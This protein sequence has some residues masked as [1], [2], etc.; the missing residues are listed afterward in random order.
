MKTGGY[1]AIIAVIFIAILVAPQF[2]NWFVEIVDKLTGEL[3]ANKGFMSIGLTIHYEDGTTEQIETEKFTLVPLTIKT[4]L[5]LPVDRLYV[6]IAVSPE[7]TIQGEK[8]PIVSYH[9]AGTF[10][11]VVWDQAETTEIADW[12]YE[13]FDRTETLPDGWESGEQKGVEAF[14]HY[15]DSLESIM[16]PHEDGVYHL[17]MS[18]D[19]TLTLQTDQLTDSMRAEGSYTWAFR[20]EKDTLEITSV[21]VDVVSIPFYG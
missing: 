19:L 13:E 1:I 7:F 8:Q 12:G 5:G 10:E 11:S 20:Y 9:V 3:T 4:M 2:G 17:V 16:A 15:C 18:A 21:S 14:S 6:V